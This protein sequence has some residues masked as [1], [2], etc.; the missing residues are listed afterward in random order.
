MLGILKWKML[1][2]ARD[3][4]NKALENR[5]KS[6]K[7]ILHEKRFERARAGTRSVLPDVAIQE[8]LLCFRHKNSLYDVQIKSYANI[9]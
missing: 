2:R 1:A 9:L 7:E 6:T 3:T 8:F 4:K 5:S